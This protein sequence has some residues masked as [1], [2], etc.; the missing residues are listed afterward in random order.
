MR[1]TIKAG[2][3]VTLIAVLL[4]LT[5]FAGSARAAEWWETVKVKGDFRYRHEM[6][7]KQDNDARHRQRIR[8]RIG[9]S[10]K[11]NEMMDIGI[12]L[13][14]GS[15]DPV[16]T[17]QTLD[18]AFSSKDIRLDLAYFTFHHE[19]AVGFT[20]TAGKMKNPF[21]T[22][23]SSELIWDSDLNPEGGAITLV[24]NLDNVEINLTGAGCW[25]DERSSSDDSYI[26][27][28]QGFV[29]FNLNKKKSSVTLGGSIY[30]YVN[31]KGFAPFYDNE[32]GMG[33]TLDTLGNYAN[34]F[35]LVEVFGEI[36]HKFDDIPVSIF[37]D[38]VSNGGAD[39][40]NTGWMF[41]FKIGHAKD[42]GS[43]DLRYNYR[44]V[45]TDA[46]VGMFTDSDFRGGGTDAKGHEFGASYQLAKNANL[47]ATYFINETG[48]ELDKTIDFNR[49]QLDVQLKF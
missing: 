1:N 13:A 22:P 33:N 30:N 34:D 48:L 4:S 20:I 19:K 2:L 32:D 38:L 36:T 8:A 31:A 10:A 45:E 18:D 17:N 14:T 25:V 44:K 46:V 16:S 40:L 23:G 49:L 9:I 5:G 41:G 12:Q 24:K 47:G 29:R 6:I 28:G 11:A 15:N 26:A 21:F 42:A 27:A 3:S 7:D 37:G 43:W 39:S 35:E